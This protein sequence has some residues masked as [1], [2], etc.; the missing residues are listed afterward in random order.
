MK[1]EGTFERIKPASLH[2]VDYIEFNAVLTGILIVWNTVLLLMLR[3]V[4]LSIE[5]YKNLQREAR[6]AAL[7]HQLAV[8]NDAES[9][10]LRES[11]QSLRV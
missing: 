1:E 11:A 6:I 5:K 10:E 8:Y 2:L 4:K 9:D 7:N 3:R